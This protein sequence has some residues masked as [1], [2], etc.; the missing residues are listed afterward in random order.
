MNV[1]EPVRKY[2]YGVAGALLIAL[3]AWG[4]LDD[5]GALVIAGLL[6]AILVIPAETARAKVTPVRRAP[7]LVD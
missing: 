4:V 5:N 3:V 2:I 1:P 7:D 6:Q